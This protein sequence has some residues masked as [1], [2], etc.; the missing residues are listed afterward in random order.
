M[1]RVLEG[2]DVASSFSDDRICSRR[3]VARIAGCTVR[4]VDLWASQGLLKRCRLPGRSRSIGFR[5]SEIKSLVFGGGE[6][7]S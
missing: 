1:L 2:P 3:E 5:Y 6:E 7:V 4:A